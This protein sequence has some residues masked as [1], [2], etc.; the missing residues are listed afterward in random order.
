MAVILIVFGVAYYVQSKNR[1][2]QR[3][4]LKSQTHSNYFAPEISPEGSCIV[5][6]LLGRGLCYLIATYVI[7]NVWETDQLMRQR[8]MVLKRF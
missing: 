6:E 7:R 4:Q 5:M 1:Q 2:V 3:N 8:E